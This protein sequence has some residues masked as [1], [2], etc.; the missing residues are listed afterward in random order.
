MARS[1]A[2]EITAAALR[3]FREKGYHAT[4]VQDI[5]NAVGLE[6]GSLYYYITSKEDFL[7][8]VA[9]RKMTALNQKL[10]EIVRS[11][12]PPQ[13]K[14]RKAIHHHVLDIANDLDT[15]T[16]LLREMHGLSVAR[17]SD[18][19]AQ[20]DTYR[21]L[22]AAILREG[23]E[24]GAFVVSDDIIVMAVLG[25]INWVYQWYRPN[26]RLTAEQIAEAYVQLFLYGLLPRSEH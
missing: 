21:H 18:I 15:M 23:Q 19:E 1:K 26:G 24:T 12:D 25:A 17:R 9:R 4:S 22:M 11:A 14:L 7:F 13:E 6:K 5:A 2:E 8:T 20:T 10:E 3:L 16:V